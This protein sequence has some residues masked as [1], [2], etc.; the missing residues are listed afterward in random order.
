MKEHCHRGLNFATRMKRQ[1]IKGCYEPLMS[2]SGSST[3]SELN[4]R[5]KA[6][7]GISSHKQVYAS[8]RKVCSLMSSRH[9]L[10]LSAGLNLLHI[11]N[12]RDEENITTLNQV[13]IKSG[14]QV[15]AT[16]LVGK[17]L[18]AKAINREGFR[19]AIQKMWNTIKGVT[20]E[21]LGGNRFIFHF[22][23][24]IDKKRV[25]RGGPWHF[26]NSLIV[27][28][29]TQWVVEEVDSGE[30]GD[31]FCSFIRVRVR[32]DITKPLRRV[33]LVKFFTQDEDAI[34]LPLLFERL[35]EFYYC[36]GMI[37][38]AYKDCE[39]MHYDAKEDNFGYGAWLKASTMAMK[40][41]Q[42]R[43]NSRGESPKKSRA[44]LRT[45]ESRRE[46][47]LTVTT[48]NPATSE[49]MKIIHQP[50]TADN[51]EEDSG[52]SVETPDLRQAPSTEVLQETPYLASTRHTDL[53]Q[54]K[55][56]CAGCKSQR[57]WKLLAWQ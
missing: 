46:R 44:E 5:E 42:G 9:S 26:N 36:C 14:E 13:V 20:V 2:C 43:Q 33:L 3:S 45:D 7:A 56:G 57:R 32:I 52:C 10:A 1:G 21:S 12:S 6:L 31:C 23:S 19:S 50:K 28:E 30:T 34:W 51:R 41:K 15:L 16:S 4:D 25:L 54:S 40:N 22:H 37:G 11:V 47:D 18:S 24:N 39:I 29:E 38:H 53:S 35:P 27:L 48:D 49:S 17:V 55:S 8:L